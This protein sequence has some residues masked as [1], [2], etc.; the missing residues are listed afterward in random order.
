[1]TLDMAGKV[2]IITTKGQGKVVQVD[3]EEVT[4]MRR[5]LLL[6]CKHVCQT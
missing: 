6:H 1:M 2:K 5:G 4:L 3:E